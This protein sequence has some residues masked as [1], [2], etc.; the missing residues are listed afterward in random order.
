M[1]YDSTEI[2]QQWLALEQELQPLSGEFAPV[3]PAQLMQRP[4]VE[5][6]T[7]IMRGELPRAPISRTL[8]FFLVEVEPGRVVFQGNP[9]SEHVNPLGS[10]HGGWISALLDSALGCAVHSLLPVGMGYTTLELKV[11]FIRAVMPDSGPLR[12][13]GKAISVG[14]RVGTA[15]GRLFDA[16]GTLFAHAT[17]TCL[18]FKPPS[19]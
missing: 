11:N 13:E 4:G 16:A 14:R 17:T 1:S 9:R 3:P 10:I 2:R 7:A 18:I 5:A 8:D 12:A 19:R 15:E 6:L